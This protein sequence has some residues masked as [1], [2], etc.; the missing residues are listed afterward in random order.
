MIESTNYQNGQQRGEQMSH[1][2]IHTIDLNFRNIAGTIASY[3]I[4]Y[5]SGAVLVE[6]G[7]GST[8]SG[9]QEGLKGLGY[10]VEDVTDVLLTHIHLDHAGAAGWLA[11]KGARIH[12]HPIGAPHMLNPEKLLAS[13]RRIY[14]EMMQ[15]LWGEFLPVPQEKLSIPLDGDVV[16]IDELEFKAIETPG[17]ANHHFAYI[18]GNVCFSGDI[19]G[20][21]LRGR[22]HISL[23]MPP[24]EFHLENWTNSVKRLREEKFSFIAPTHFNLYDDS[25]WHLDAL[26]CALIEAEKWMEEILPTNPSIE[27]LRLSITEW[28]HQRLENSGLDDGHESAQYAANPPFMSADGVYRYWQKFR[29][30]DN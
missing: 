11:Q 6:S 28:E 7:P 24:P 3:L 18:F 8:I 19:G 26:D 2:T 22:R 15:P 16:K 20:V 12:V 14:G 29:S 4:P 23:P 21:R 1:P 10:R 17:H 30:G 9:L 5:R 13:A 27:S 25:D